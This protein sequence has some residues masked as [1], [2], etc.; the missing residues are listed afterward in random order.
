MNLHPLEII[1][2]ILCLV[3]L[4]AVIIFFKRKNQPSNHYELL[5]K[6]LNN[7]KYQDLLTL[8]KG[9][10]EINFL[11]QEILKCKKQLHWRLFNKK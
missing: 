6:N 4:G 9:H 7:Q 8:E 11:E 3:S 2:L 5:I 1:I 10:K